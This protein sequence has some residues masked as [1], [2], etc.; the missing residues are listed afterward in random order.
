[1]LCECFSNIFDAIVFCFSNI[2][3]AKKVCYR[4]HKKIIHHRV[5]DASVLK[6]NAL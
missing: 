6:S 3:D 4:T 5:V 1:M 2:F